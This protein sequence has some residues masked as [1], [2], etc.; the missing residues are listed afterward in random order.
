LSN[1]DSNA[2]LNNDEKDRS[3]AKQQSLFQK[4]AAFLREEGI[5]AKVVRK[6]NYQ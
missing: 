3:E 5:D 4:I 1:K 6:I 2:L